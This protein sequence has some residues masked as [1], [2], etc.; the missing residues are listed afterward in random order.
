MEKF[1]FRRAIYKDYQGAFATAAQ[2]RNGSIQI[3]PFHTEN[4]NWGM[5]LANKTAV[6]NIICSDWDI[7][8]DGSMISLYNGKSIKGTIYFFNE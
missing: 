7:N 8:E 1:S 4:S 3:E 6:I 5:T 2:M